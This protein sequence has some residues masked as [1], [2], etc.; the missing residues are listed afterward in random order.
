MKPRKVLLSASLLNPLKSKNVSIA[1]TEPVED[2]YGDNIV[3]SLRM[4]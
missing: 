3:I 1:L 2:Y 4:F